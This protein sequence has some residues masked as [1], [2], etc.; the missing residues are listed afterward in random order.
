MPQAVFQNGSDR[1]PNRER[2]ALGERAGGLIEKGVGLAEREIGPSGQS[3][4]LDGQSERP[5]GQSGWWIG[6]S[7]RPN[8]QSESVGGKRGSSRV[9]ASAPQTAPLKELSRKFRKLGEKSAGTTRPLS[10]FRPVPIRTP[11]SLGAIAE[12]DVIIQSVRISINLSASRITLNAS[13]LSH[14]CKNVAVF[15]EVVRRSSCFRQDRS[16]RN[17]SKIQ[18]LKFL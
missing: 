7:G 16:G 11:V 2:I 1:P 12:K 14:L 9:W 3:D 17:Q 5:I 8:G 15:E 10:P 13:R 18:N 6:Q 4:C